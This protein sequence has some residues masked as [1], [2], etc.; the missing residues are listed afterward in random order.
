MGQNPVKY[1]CSELDYLLRTNFVV[2]LYIYRYRLKNDTIY[3]RGIRES[4]FDDA[5]LGL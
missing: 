4:P 5:Y 1:W 3:K 2:V